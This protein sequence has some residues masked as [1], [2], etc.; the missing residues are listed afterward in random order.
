M[1]KRY[2]EMEQFIREILKMYNCDK[3]CIIDGSHWYGL[4]GE[5]CYIDE[6]NKLQFQCD[7]TLRSIYKIAHKIF[8]NTKVHQDERIFV[9]SEYD[10]VLILFNNAHTNK[11]NSDLYILSNGQVYDAFNRYWYDI[12]AS[13]VLKKWLKKGYIYTDPK[14]FFNDQYKESDDKPDSYYGFGGWEE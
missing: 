3:L 2:Q 11:Y 4:Y 13:K 9:T 7:E 1:S 6:Y 8:M 10:G 12:Y 5:V 14:D